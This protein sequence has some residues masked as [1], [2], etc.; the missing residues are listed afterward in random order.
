MRNFKEKIAGIEKGSLRGSLFILLAVIALLLLFYVGI[1]YFTSYSYNFGAPILG[2]AEIKD[3]GQ[4]ES[5]RVITHIETPNSV[6]GI[7]MS[8][9][10]SGTPGFRD[11]LV[12]LIEETELNS[13]IIDIKDYTGKIG[14]PSEHPDLKNS[15]SDECGAYDIVDFI[16]LLHKKGIYTI[17]RLTVFQDPFYTET[18]PELAVKKASD[19]SVVWKD[20]KGLSFIDVGSRAFWDYIV[21]LS[22]ESYAL[23][24]DEINFDYIR[25]PSDGNMKDIYF[26]FS[27]GREKP[28]VLEEFFSHLHENLKDTGA[29]LSADLFG[30]TTTNKDDLNI[31]QVLERALPYFDYIAP[32]VYPSH[33]PTNFNGWANP[34]S[35][36]YE[37]IHLSM[38][39][40]VDRVR[41][42]S[43]DASTTPEV[44][45]RL[46][47]SQLRPWLQDFNLGAVYT[48]E[49]V[50]K[51]IQATYDV[52]LNSWMLWDAGNTYTREALLSASTTT[53]SQ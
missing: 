12:S 48:P 47:T 30:M 44:K 34:A 28:V 3:E 49:M 32:M 9:C 36:P 51:Q 27:D 24:F 39:S 5:V 43:L 7:Y 25:F 35:L 20:Y 18:H 19:T 1:P 29:K 46:S 50:R 6:K 16:D 11:S 23:G 37:V 14:F 21:T 10:V 41:A 52:G 33:Y 53:P 15:V 22:K 17:A 40:A 26:P 38:S 45:A 4:K 8:Q 13:V 42:M 2:G 31:G